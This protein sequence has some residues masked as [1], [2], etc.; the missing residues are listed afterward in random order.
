VLGVGIFEKILL[1]LFIVSL[2]TRKVVRSA[3]AGRINYQ[4]KKLAPFVVGLLLAIWVS[5]IYLV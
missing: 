4:A 5:F 3:I 2:K 1:G